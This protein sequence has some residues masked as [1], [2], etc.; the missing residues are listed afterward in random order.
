VPLEPYSKHH[1]D[2]VE[3]T[4]LGMAIGSLHEQLFGR[5]IV[6]GDRE[7]SARFNDDIAH[8]AA[9]VV[10]FVPHVRWFG[11]GV[12]RMLLLHNPNATD[13][14]R[15][16]L[17]MTDN[18]IGGAAMNA[19]GKASSFGLIQRETAGRIGFGLEAEATNYFATGVGLGLVRGITDDRVWVDENGRLRAADPGTIVRTGLYSGIANI[20]AGFAGARIASLAGQS[21]SALSR[22][23]TGIAAGGVSGGMFS[24]TDAF[25]R[26]GN[27]GDAAS[28]FLTG[29]AVGG[30]VGGAT[31][32][33]ERGRQDSFHWIYNKLRAEPI[34]EGASGPLISA[35]NL[36]PAAQRALE[37]HGK[38]LNF[39]PDSRP[40]SALRDQ[41]GAPKPGTYQ[42][43]IM[44][45]YGPANFWSDLQYRTSIVRPLREAL[46]YQSGDT[47]IVVPKNYA[48]KLDEVRQLRLDAE[49][50]NQQSIKTL[51]EH[52]L[53][54][55]LLPED[56]LPLL[57]RLPNR[58]KVKEVQ[59]LGD[60]NA[61]N[62]WYE[63]FNDW[64]RIRKAEGAKPFTA[65]ADAWA[66]NGHIRFF[67]A[68][69]G[70]WSRSVGEV[71]DH[72][73]VHLNHDPSYR[74]ARQFDQTMEITQY[75]YFNN[76]ESEA[77]LEAVAFWGATPRFLEAAQQAPIRMSLLANKLRTAG[78][79]GSET[80]AERIKYVDE[81][82]LPEANRILTEQA[83]KWR[84]LRNRSSYNDAVDLL[85]VLNKRS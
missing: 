77:E 16:I 78:G 62:G 84:Q 4:E 22:I 14:G 8:V 40:L 65:A 27:V 21:T 67:E 51:S 64:A 52:P 82:S 25:V 30:I 5:P 12:A 9:D 75:G 73:Q 35:E 81:H 3:H 18:F 60:A 33:L 36:S 42:S 58:A 10:A 23:G 48:A 56:L 38:S 45:P 54:S 43:E 55:R 80:I 83:E 59:L 49:S 15:E 28:G 19:I 26:T 71:M 74:I 29:V 50:G 47:Q 11:A 31:A 39:E 46:V 57:D 68:P 53:K 66:K 32:G 72:E 37:V 85:T 17:S 44:N 6:A 69:K 76:K 79:T 63:E 20:P 70:T 1:P 7:T 41:L 24:A 61:W 13:S 2:R 34:R